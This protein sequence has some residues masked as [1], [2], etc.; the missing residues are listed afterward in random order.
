MI[1]GLNGWLNYLDQVQLPVLRQTLLRI[2]KIT[3]NDRATVSRLAEAIMY[4][5]DLAS[6][7][8]K[9]A[10]S[11]MFNP[12]KTSINTV[13]RAIMVIGFN[14]VKSMAITSLLVDNLKNSA[15][16]ANLYQCL[17]RSIHAAIHAKSLA[18]HYPIGTQEEIFVDTILFNIGEAAFW[19]SD[20][21]E[22]SELAKLP[23][24]ALDANLQR[25]QLGTTFRAISKGL[26]QQWHFSPLLE[27]ALHNPRGDQAKIIYQ[28][29]M[30]ANLASVDQEFSDQKACVRLY[31]SLTGADDK[32]ATQQIQSN[33]EKAIQVAKLL[34]ITDAEKYLTQKTELEMAPVQPDPIKHI[35][36]LHKMNQCDDGRLSDDLLNHTLMG[37]HMGVGFERSAAF[38]CRTPSAGASTESIKQMQLY[39]SVGAGRNQWFTGRTLQMASRLEPGTVYY[40]NELEEFMGKQQ[41]RGASNALESSALSLNHVLEAPFGS[42][43]VPALVTRIGLA[44]NYYLL[45]YADR[46]QLAPITDDQEQGFR[47]FV[48]LLLFKLSQRKANQAT[49]SVAN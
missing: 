36:F 44:N 15:H 32:K 24:V 46:C 48:D 35:E 11:A 13:T 43:V 47:L 33:R 45:I 20:T 28:S 25:E 38:L 39:L 17:A 6:N 37:L 34:G 27:E 31:A 30:I 10:N 29:N 3:D 7:V 2:V 49:L 12:S 18:Q 21:K 19:A 4:D 5:A 26:V 42:S 23:N 8:L 40:L 9:L 1:K 16:K 41:G 14:S 22:I